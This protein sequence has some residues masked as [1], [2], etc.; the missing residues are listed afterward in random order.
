MFIITWWYDRYNNCF[1]KCIYNLIENLLLS[2]LRFCIESSLVQTG[3]HWRELSSRFLW[4]N[5]RGV[6]LARLHTLHSAAAH[7]KASQ[8]L[9]SVSW[10][11][12]ACLTKQNNYKTCSDSPENRNTHSLAHFISPL[13]RW[14]S[15]E[16]S[17]RVVIGLCRLSG[18]RGGSRSASGPEWLRSQVLFCWKAD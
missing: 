14:S 12:A 13:S 8:F 4:W 7:C 15:S 18:I 16:A 10:S 11:A 1:N 17:P 3:G 5:K 6:T 2:F 9:S